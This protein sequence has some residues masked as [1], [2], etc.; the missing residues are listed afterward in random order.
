MQ[1]LHITIQSN[2]RASRFL[3]VSYAVNLEKN[4][5]QLLLKLPQW[6]PG[7][8]E[9]QNYAKNLMY[10]SATDQNGQALP[11][12][13]VD[14]NTWLVNTDSAQ[15]ANINYKY[16]AYQQDAGGSYID[17]DLIYLNPV[18][19]CMEVEGYDLPFDFTLNVGKPT[20]ISCGLPLLHT[21]DHCYTSKCNSWYE[22]YD[23]PIFASENLLKIS[24][25]VAETVF[26]L[27]FYGI[28]KVSN[29]EKIIKD[30]RAF[31]KYQLEIFG[32]FPFNDY[33]FQFLILPYR[34]Y[35]GVE[36]RNSTVIVLGNA[37]D[38]ENDLLNSDFLGISSHELFHAWN[39]CK[40]RPMELS[41]YNYHQENY[42]DTGFVAE[43]FTTFLGD[44]IL[45]KTGVYSKSEYET[46]LK[47][48]I[49]R[50][51][52]NFGNLQA[53]LAQSSLD[54][55]IDGY[56]PSHQERKVSI[57]D[58]GALVA[59]IFHAEILK[60]TQDKY[61]LESVLQVLYTQYALQNKGYTAT[62]VLNIMKSFAGA[63]IQVV[64]EE[65]IYQKTFLKE[66]LKDTLQ[67][68]NLEIDLEALWLSPLRTKGYLSTNKD[69]KE[70]VEKLNPEHPIS[71]YLAINDQIL[72]QEGDN[73]TILRNGRIIDGQL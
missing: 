14:K 59:L 55:W 18:N 38:F 65:C 19:C 2:Y 27:W 66:K 64:F 45:Y 13:K 67:Y 61:S 23:S 26:N 40:I 11:W 15:I 57:Y 7:R 44:Y 58:K 34:Y 17:D 43:G 32:S 39:I 36:H 73:F 20:Q 22:L 69:G 50:H 70:M 29:T 62:D 71:K 56:Q 52:G 12:H 49:S 33:H 60:K 10:F 9:N 37:E 8:Y 16:Y 28:S 72:K 47:A 6:R 3:E 21:K 30:F 35:H 68:L 54:L 48:V 63:E 42:F 41:P 4:D 5:Q 46:E 51:F 25:D 31:T 1:H 53:S 24:Y